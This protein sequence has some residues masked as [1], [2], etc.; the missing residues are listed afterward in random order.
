MV[1][2]TE[3]GEDSEILVWSVDELGIRLL[4]RIGD[5][6]L[7]GYIGSMDSLGTWFAT[8]GPLP[9]NRL[10]S[11]RA[12]AAAEPILLRRG[13]AGYVQG[14]TVSPDGRWLATNHML[15]LTM[16]PL[17]R[18]QPA[19]IPVDLDFWVGGLVFDPEGRFL[20]FSADKT[21]TV[22][23]LEPQVPRP[24][25]VAFTAGTFFHSFAVSP[26]G[27][28][29]AVG[30]D[31]GELWIGTNDGRQPVLLADPTDWGMGTHNVT[32]SL[33]GRYLAFL[34]GLYDLSTAVF[35][36]WN[37]ESDTEQ[38]TLQLPGA[39]FRFGVSFSSD[40]RLL[41]ATTKGVVA[42]NVESGEHEVLVEGGVAAFTSSRDGRRLLFIEEGESGLQQDL[43]GT[44]IFVDL[45]AGVST[46]LMTHGMEITAA[47]LDQDGSIAVTGDRNGII[48]VGRVS[49]EEPH[50]LMGHE[51]KIRHIAIDPLGRWIASA[52]EDDTVRLWPMPDLSK[53]P[54]HTLPRE[55]LIAKLK[56]LT[57]LRVV[58]DP[59]TATGWKLTHDP[60]PG[61]AEVPEW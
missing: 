18:P 42:W 26:D 23:P 41:T 37:L 44:P 32:F 5:A 2:L 21:V 40:G 49:G 47:A 48:R 22:V 20:A 29:F 34:T 12:P 60:F 25:G 58:R 54:L 56:T 57:N 30:D 3:T 16:W 33:D 35:R 55:E 27:Q 11:L 24:G 6:E 8:R 59:D 10:W 15:G 43:A 38:A 13:Q 9:D 1:A 4:R 14:V 50:I 17:V 46:P 31:S 7:M 45:D 28:R 51:G 39:E 52:G 19:V 36:V 53:P 61:W